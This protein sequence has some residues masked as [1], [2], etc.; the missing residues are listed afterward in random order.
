MAG[1]TIELTVDALGAD[2]E[3]LETGKLI[4]AASASAG[5]AS[6]SPAAVIRC[7]PAGAKQLSRQECHYAEFEI[8]RG[9][10]ALIGVACADE[11]LRASG[12]STTENGWGISTDQGTLFHNTSVWH[13]APSNAKGS[14]FLPAAQ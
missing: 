10:R 6:I 4:T 9:S 14:P 2:V 8:I 12:L 13:T 1:D 11:S 5:A 7:L 3:T